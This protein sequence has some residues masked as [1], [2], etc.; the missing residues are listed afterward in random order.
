MA[1]FVIAGTLL[2]ALMARLTAWRRRIRLVRAYRGFDRYQ[3]R[4]LGIETL[5]LS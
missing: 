3:R 5:D 2:V 4:D 1:Q